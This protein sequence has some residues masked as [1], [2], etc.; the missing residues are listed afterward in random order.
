MTWRRADRVG[1]PV[2]VKAKGSGISR[3][4]IIVDRHGRDVYKIVITDSDIRMTGWNLC[5]IS[6]EDG[7]KDVGLFHEEYLI[8]GRRREDDRDL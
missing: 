4:G 2:L 5:S 1:D 7:L 6:R 3:P 8:F